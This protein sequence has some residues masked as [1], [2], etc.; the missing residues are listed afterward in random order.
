M[1]MA[2]SLQMRLCPERRGEIARIRDSGR[3]GLACD[4]GARRRG[5]MIANDPEEIEVFVRLK[6]EDT[7]DGLQA[8][9][10][11][12]DVNKKISGTPLVAIVS[13]KEEAKQKAKALARSLGCKTYGIVD[14]TNSGRTAPVPL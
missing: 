6:L 9:I 4:G 13:D 10:S 12:L 7:L 1:Q 5:A 2:G 3:R 11:Q 8:T 14:K